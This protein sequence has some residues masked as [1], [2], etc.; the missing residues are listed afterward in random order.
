MKLII[1]RHGQAEHNVPGLM[2]GHGES[3]LTEKGKSQVRDIANRLRD[4]HIDGAFSSDLERAV[5][6][7]QGILQFHPN[8]KLEKT[9]A[10]REQMF[11]DLERTTKDNFAAKVKEAGVAWFAYTP[12]GGESMFE[13]K[14]RAAT[15]SSSILEEWKGKTVLIVSHGGFIRAL[16]CHLLGI[17]FDEFP[18]KS[19][20]T[21]LTIIEVDEDGQHHVHLL[22]DGS[23]LPE[24]TDSI[25]EEK[26]RT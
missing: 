7:A 20:N 1:V 19:Y 18:K 13:T 2:V 25:G 4:E 16:V 15:F 23:H 21:G 14:S 26:A 5:Q 12:P 17:D 6:T 11:G 22:N 24:V 10:L 3:A 9:A 8:V